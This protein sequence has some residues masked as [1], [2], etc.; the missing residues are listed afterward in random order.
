MPITSRRATSLPDV[1]ADRGNVV[2]MLRTNA[3]AV[4]HSLIVVSLTAFLAGCPQPPATEDP[5]PPLYGG[6]FPG[7]QVTIEKVVIPS[8]LRPE[9]TF[10]ATDERGEIVAMSE[11]TDARFILDYLEEVPS[12]PTARFVSY[13]TRTEDPDRTPNSGDEA[14]Q[15]DYDG[16]R[17]GGVTQNDD[18]SFLY[19]FRTAIPSNYDKTLT[20]QV[21][22]QFRRLFG[23]DG[24]SYPANAVLTFRP[25]GNSAIK[26]REVVETASCNTC[27]TRLSVHGDIRREVQLCILCHNSQTSDGNTGNSLDFPQL[28]HKIHRGAELPSV[29]AGGSYGIGG[30]SGI[31]DYSTVEFPQD[32]RN[33]AVCHSASSKAVDAEFHLKNPSLAGCASCHDRTWFGMANATPEGYTNHPIPNVNDTQCATCHNQGLLDIADSHLT[34]AER[35]GPGLALQVLEVNAAAA[36][37][38]GGTEVQILFS[39]VDGAGQPI[40]NPAGMTFAATVGWPVSDYE[41][42]VREAIV[43]PNGSAPAG[44]LVNNNDG[45]YSYTFSALFDGGADVTYAVGMEGRRPYMTDEGATLNQG[46]ATNGMLNFTL[47]GSKGVDQ[48]RTIVSDAKCAVCH[49]EVR[50]HGELRVGV[51]YCVLCHNPNGTDE[52][53]RPEDAMPPETINFKDMIH[54]IHTGEELNSGYTLYG[55][56]GSSTDFSEVRFPARREQCTVCHENGTFG[57]PTP[58]EALSTMV[59]Q[60]LDGPT[61]INNILPQQAACTSC[62][63]D[64]FTAAHAMLA[65]SAGV[66]SC[67][68]CHGSG[69]EFAVESIH[70][71]GP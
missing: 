38:G 51:Q 17:I 70:S 64:V 2:Y 50:M 8:D 69:A 20:H 5:L 66:E 18:G 1:P 22:G 28:I 11:L 21:G 23:A 44:T 35:F 36:S 57:V 59:V 29:L 46:T 65:T 16:A 19:K 52:S 14:V 6:L 41:Q 58:E 71:I 49:D 53:R 9:V 10:T 31:E 61:V 60:E 40:T 32:I 12:R 43:N 27:H 4:V 25:D 47:N 3:S 42:A 26:T 24:V 34:E 33:C 54:R 63:D 15:S 45:T 68:V 48:R 30:F 62:H 7:L 37:K 56:G 55:F 39:A 67:S 13:T